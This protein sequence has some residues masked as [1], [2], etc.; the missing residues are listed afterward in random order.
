M[1]N[2]IS[3]RLQV[4]SHIKVWDQLCRQFPKDRA[5][6]K[7]IRFERQGITFDLFRCH[8]WRAA[9]QIYLSDNAFPLHSPRSVILY[10]NSGYSLTCEIYFSS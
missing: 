8:P 9:N 7:N 5:K 10:E 3:D 2:G 6:R 4:V 1:T